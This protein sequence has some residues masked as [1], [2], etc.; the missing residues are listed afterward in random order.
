MRSSDI[1]RMIAAK[2]A[3]LAASSDVSSRTANMKAASAAARSLGAQTAGG[4]AA[5]APSG[6]QGTGFF[7]ASNLAAARGLTPVWLTYSRALGALVLVFV[8]IFASSKGHVARRVGAQVERWSGN[9]IYAP[10]SAALRPPMPPYPAAP[11]FDPTKVK[12]SDIERV[13]RARTRG[14]VATSHAFTHHHNR[15]AWRL[16]KA[17]SWERASTLRDAHPELRAAMDTPNAPPP[18]PPLPHKFL[19]VK[20]VYKMNYT[21]ALHHE[22]HRREHVF[23]GHNYQISPPPPRFTPPPYVPNAPEA[24]DPDL[25]PALRTG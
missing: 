25:L 19:T 2:K 16:E 7:D 10:G 23:R 17:Q 4:A 14:Q 3:Q 15:D 11:T 22:R 5:G 9:A 1:A 12:H 18:V 6:R 13:A 8:L 20:D 21:D 24:P